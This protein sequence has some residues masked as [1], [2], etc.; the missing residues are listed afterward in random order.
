MAGSGI[1]GIRFLLELDKGVIKDI[2][3][4]DYSL[5]AVKNINDN[6]KLNKIKK[7]KKINITNKDANLF[8]LESCGFDYIDIDPFGT[9]NPFLDSAVKRVSREGILAVTATD[10]A[11]LAGTYP[12]AC[13]RKYWAKPLHDE[14]MHEVGLR[15]LIR[16]CQL[17]GSQF[18]KALIPIFSYFKDH[19]FRVFFRCIKGKKECDKVIAEHG[20]FN[21][22]GPMWLGDLWDSGLVNKMMKNNEIKENEKILAVIKEECKVKTVGFFD[23]HALA[24]KNKV[25]ELPKIDD[26]IAKIKKKG[27]KASRTHFSGTGV[28]SDCS[29]TEIIRL[30]K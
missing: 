26:L 7:T 24:K 22:A 3:I 11:P 21:S 13:L 25:K 30:I 16:K 10:T 9:P 6:L 29:T 20:M 5:D 8:L 18:D 19:Y 17:V 15:I 27:H 23:I 4:N 28:R 1:R 12:S 14:N 2:T